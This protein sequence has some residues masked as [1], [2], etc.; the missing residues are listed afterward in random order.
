M[1]GGGGFELM[2]KRWSIAART[3]TNT[4]PTTRSTAHAAR[5]DRDGNR[6]ASPAVTTAGTTIATPSSKTGRPRRPGTRARHVNYVCQ[7]D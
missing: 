6:C 1:A 7:V 2:R 4:T 5:P 3:S